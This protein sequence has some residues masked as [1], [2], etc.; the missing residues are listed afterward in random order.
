MATAAENK[1][2]APHLT[3]PR[4]ASLHGEG[5]RRRACSCYSQDAF[6]V[7]LSSFSISPMTSPFDSGP[8][9]NVAAGVL[10]VDLDALADNWRLLARHIAPAECAAAI[11]ANAYGIGFEPAARALLAAGCKTFFV[12]QIDE[13]VQA[14][15]ALGVRPRIFVDLQR[16]CRLRPI[17]PITSRILLSGDRLHGGAR[18]LGALRR[19]WSALCNPCRYRHEPARLRFARRARNGARAA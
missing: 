10:T 7:I 4:S 19:G 5:V 14:R 3:S 15:R 6:T 12:A 18:A 11:K 13:G 2:P 9:L 1:R 17:L 16:P 8:P